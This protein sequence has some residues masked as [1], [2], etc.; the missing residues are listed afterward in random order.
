MD[1]SKDERTQTVQKHHTNYPPTRE[2]I[3]RKKNRHINCNTIHSA[4]NHPDPDSMVTI[5]NNNSLVIQRLNTTLWSA[6]YH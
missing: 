5:R 6:S 1:Q 3:K 2:K 4:L